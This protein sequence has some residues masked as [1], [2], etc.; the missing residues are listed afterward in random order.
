MFFWQYSFSIK[1]FSIFAFQIFANYFLD[2]SPFSFLFSLCHSIWFY[3][4]SFR[5]IS[6]HSNSVLFSSSN[7]NSLQLSIFIL[8]NQ[9]NRVHNNFCTF[10]QKQSKSNQIK[11]N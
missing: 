9:S 7:F 2:R 8:S 5:F 11:S 6:F 10:D 3:F 1:S 4:I